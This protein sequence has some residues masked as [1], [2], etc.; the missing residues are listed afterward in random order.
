[1]NMTHIVWM[2]LPTA[3]A[4]G[5]GDRIAHAVRTLGLVPE[6]VVA[7]SDDGSG[8]VVPSA[9]AARLADVFRAFEDVAGGNTLGF[10]LTLGRGS[11]VVGCHTVG[12]RR[13]LLMRFRHQD[14]DQLDTTMPGRRFLDLIATLHGASSAQD[15]IWARDMTPADI[16]ELIATDG[17]DLSPGDLD[18]VAAVANV[19]PELSALM[20]LVAGTTWRGGL[21]L[22][23]RTWAEPK[24]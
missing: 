17:R 23:A 14:F 15:V 18:N 9:T 7:L 16:V 13:G 2:T 5:R 4:A 20:A 3:G 6:D 12:A 22:H 11:L 8:D 1:M 19:G 24:H 10:R 21:C